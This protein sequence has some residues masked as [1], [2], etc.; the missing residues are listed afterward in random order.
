MLQIETTAIFRNRD[1]SGTT[2]FIPRVTRLADGML[3]MT[4]Q[5]ITGSDYYHAVHCCLSGDNGRTWSDLEIIHAFD[6]VGLEDG[7]EEGVCDVV[8]AFHHRTGTV[9]ALG[10]NVFYRD[11]GLLDTLGDFCDG[12]HRKFRRH[13]VYIIRDRIGDWSREY[14]VLE[15]EPFSEC[16]IYTSGCAQT[17]EAPDGG[18]LIPL[19]FGYWGRRDRM[20]TVLRCDFDGVTLTP[21]CHGSILELAEDRGLLEPSLVEFDNRIFLTIRAEDGHGY[22]SVSGNGLDYES[23]R[24]WAWD[25]GTP[26]VMSTTQQHWLVHR[27]RLYLV[28]T[29]RTEDN[30]EVMRWRSPLFIAE[31]DPQT[32][33]LKRDSEQVIFPMYDP[34]T[35][36]IA[37]MGNFHTLSPGPD[38]SIV[39]VG[40]ISPENNWQGD[41]LIAWI[42]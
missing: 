24:P 41:T 9:L 22:V 14:R 36:S 5:P 29:R 6:R 1:G 12:T 39:T 26:L 2:Y 11:G 25:D 35:G 33:C 38:E 18:L 17:I 20:V 27:E 19:S 42:R 40:E 8:P 16:S 31:V 4:T 15:Y 21:V 3:L 28:Y 7:V 34:G 10:Q 30:T 37:R 23:L 32:V 13:V